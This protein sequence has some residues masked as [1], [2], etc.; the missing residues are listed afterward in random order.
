MFKLIWSSVLQIIS[1]GAGPK[2]NILK[3]KCLLQSTAH[4]AE[5]NSLMKNM[6]P[7]HDVPEFRPDTVPLL[8]ACGQ[9]R[10][11]EFTKD[12]GRWWGWRGVC[13][14]SR[15]LARVQEREGGG[16]GPNRKRWGH[17]QKWERRE[18]QTGRGEH[19]EEWHWFR[20]ELSCKGVGCPLSPPSLPTSLGS[21]VSPAGLAAASVLLW[22]RG[23]RPPQ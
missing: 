3:A 20:D 7:G 15:W 21:S 10:C 5:T 8:A 1:R 22:Q 18:R 16:A 11:E 4:E 9:R 14:S 12:T 6:I 13:C 17:S 23:I 19:W 2:P